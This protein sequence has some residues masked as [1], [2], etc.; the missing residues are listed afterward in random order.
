M[1]RL[2]TLHVYASDVGD[3]EGLNRL[4]S[5]IRIYCHAE[6]AEEI[7]RLYPDNGYELIIS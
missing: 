6:Q 3:F 4:K 1:Q 2:E 5:L 7:K